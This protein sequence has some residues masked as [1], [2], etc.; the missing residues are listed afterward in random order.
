MAMQPHVRAMKA[1]TRIAGKKGSVTRRALVEAA[2]V[3]PKVAAKALKGLVADGILKQQ[4]TTRNTT[5][6]PA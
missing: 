2:I 5:Y 4:G 6:V 3:E 1:A